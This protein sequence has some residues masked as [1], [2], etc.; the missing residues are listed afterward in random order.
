MESA[1]KHTIGSVPASGAEAAGY[2]FGIFAILIAVLIG[3]IKC[4]AIMRRPATCGLC[5]SSLLVFLI[6][7]LLSSSLQALKAVTGGAVPPFVTV[8]IGLLAIAGVITGVVLG[9][10]GLARYA[11]SGRF[12]QGRKQAIWGLIL[13]GCV[14]LL[15]FGGMVTAMVRTVANA[16]KAGG[17]GSSSESFAKDG[18][19]KVFEDLNFK[20]VMPGK[21]WVALDPEKVNP[22]ASLC[23]ASRSP[24]RIFFVIAEP[25]G[26][27]IDLDVEGLAEIAKGYLESSAQSVAFGEIETR[28]VNGR[29]FLTLASTAR[30]IAKP[31]DEFHYEHWFAAQGGFYYQLITYTMMSGP[32][33]LAVSAS[34][35]AERFEI[36]DPERIIHSAGGHAAPE[37]EFPGLGFSIDP[38]ETG[39][40]EWRSAD[41]DYPEAQY[42]ALKGSDYGFGVVALDLLDLDPDL[43]ALASGFLSSVFDLEFPDKVGPPREIESGIARGYAIEARGGD[44]SN[45]FLYRFRILRAGN[46]AWLLSAWFTGGDPEKAS[47]VEEMLDAVRVFA[48]D[49]DAAPREWP[50]GVREGSAGIYNQTGLAYFKRGDYAASRAWFEAASRTDESNAQYFENVF[51]AMMRAGNPEEG[52]ALAESGIAKFPDRSRLRAYRAQFFSAGERFDEARAAFA[53][54]FKE[55]HSDEDDLLDYLNLLVDAEQR[56]AAVETLREFR[57]AR[58]QPGTNLDRWEASLLSQM[59]HHDEAVALL[60]ATLEK[61]PASGTVAYALTTALLEAERYT[62]ALEKSQAMIDDGHGGAEVYVLKGRSEMGLEWYRKARDSFLKARE[63]D[64]EN[65]EV[66]QY[67]DHASAALG[68]GNTASINVP[69]EAVPEP[70]E[71]TALAARWREEHGPHLSEDFGYQILR[72]VYGISF[73][74]GKPRKTTG[75]SS[76]RILDNSGVNQYSTLKFGFDSLGERVFVNEVRILDEEGKVVSTGDVEDYYVMDDTSDGHASTAKML[77]VPV[78]GLQPS[79]TLEYTFTQEDLGN[80]DEFEFTDY[81]MAQRGPITGIIVFVAGDVEQLRWETHGDVETLKAENLIAWHKEKPEI[82]RAEEYLPRVETMLP[83][84]WIGDKSPTWKSEAE[85]YLES[86]QDVLK[87]G[88]A[89]LDA[90]TADLMKGR[91]ELDSKVF[92]A[93]SFVQDRLT[94]QA[95]EFGKRARIPNPAAVSLENKYGDCKDHSVLL[96]R[97]LREAKIPASLALISTGSDVREKIPSL[98]QFNHMIVHV[99]GLKGARFVDCTSKGFPSGAVSPEFLGDEAALVLDPENIRFERTLPYA[100]EQCAIECE[101]RISFAENS[102]NLIVKETASFH[103]YYAAW[104]RRYFKDKKVADYKRDLAEM[105]NFYGEPVIRELDLE[106]RDENHEPMIVNWTYEMRHCIS[107]GDRGFSIR[108][109]AVWE[110]YFLKKHDSGERY[111]P[112]EIPLPLHFISRAKLDPGKAGKIVTAP[113]LFRKSSETEFSSI[114]CDAKLDADTGSLEV[115]NEFKQKTGRFPAESFSSFVN[116][117]NDALNLWRTEV[118]IETR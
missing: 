53:D 63:F 3:I 89:E 100:P 14:L 79:Y 11:G 118:R 95:I 91:E 54:A 65:E 114:A 23:L 98:D 93:V 18:E 86:I 78:P 17:G 107:P 94:Y 82:L 38:P 56:E 58:T 21:P 22:D 75:S 36:L 48:A 15:I 117:S 55:G 51:E 25:L 44:E 7:M 80:S 35:L 39:W 42:T 83:Y 59:E 84:L 27:D 28:T 40:V 57:A 13:H 96:Y 102:E 61:H 116:H 97:L 6:L 62:E 4:I 87:E 99:P 85:E 8:L 74:K 33:E 103:G 47:E 16:G 110:A 29:D 52:I 37:A 12:N 88:G 30:G 109:P 71:I 46:R 50:G 19:E 43:D 32:E 20:F 9:I 90:L 67:L 73:E 66:R 64:E 108:W 113:S 81:L 104:V 105:L 106:N 2:Y 77:N 69:I 45:R 60:K 31:D 68:K 10:V 115:V 70:A 34:R 72:R 5:V 41:E 26:V 1:S 112:F 76:V 92:A 101:R 111:H 49:E 24:Q